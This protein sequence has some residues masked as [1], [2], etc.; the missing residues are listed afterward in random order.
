MSDP[1]ETSELVAFT[2]TVDAKSLSRAAAELRIPRATV[3]RRLAR[4]EERLGARLLRRT[5]RSL[6]LTDVG[7]VFYREACIALE[8][9]RL[10]EQSVR[11]TDD[12]VRGDL[13]VSVP[14]M[15]RGGFHAMLCEFAARYPELRVHVHTSNHHVDLLR[16]DYDVALRASSQ[17]EPGLIARTLLRD[18]MIA[19][20]SPAY[21][22]DHGAPRTHRDLKHHNCLL[23]F[24]RGELPET[25]W[26]MTSGGK[27]YVE[28]TFFSND[29]ALLCE[30]VVNGLG[31]AL[32]PRNLVSPHLESGA[33]LQVLDGVV[34][35]E[36]HIALVYPERT[37][38]L[39]QVRAF[40]DAVAA[41]LPHEDAASHGTSQRKLSGATTQP[42]K[43]APRP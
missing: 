7:E 14:P 36:M 16:G 11:R 40:I 13:R 27:L 15:M 38:L 25:H 4:L 33:L 39:P 21:L 23:G 18:P 12:V 28:G 3:S 26:P 10:A 19:V 35:I 17:I 34:G 1:I 32:L 29:I 31:I 37:F 6:V 41:W 22:A 30:A 5:T 24:T 20:A 9:V 2:K 8:A 42:K 43:A